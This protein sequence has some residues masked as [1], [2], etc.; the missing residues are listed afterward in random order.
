MRMNHS[1]KAHAAMR[2]IASNEW[3]VKMWEHYNRTSP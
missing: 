2:G 1:I 3:F